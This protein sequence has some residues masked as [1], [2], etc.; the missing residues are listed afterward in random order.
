MPIHGKVQN[1]RIVLDR[2]QELPEGSQVAVRIITARQ[3]AGKRGN[4]RK[5]P[6]RSR[7]L[8]HAGKVRDLPADAARNLDHYLYGYLKK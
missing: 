7:L 2:G 4:T 3:T 1:G 8:K 5:K 6:Q